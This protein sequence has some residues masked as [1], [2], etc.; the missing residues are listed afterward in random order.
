MTSNKILILISIFLSVCSIE[1]NGAWNLNN[2]TKLLP[3]GMIGSCPYFGNP[4]VFSSDGK[5]VSIG[6]LGDNS[7][8]CNSYAAGSIWNYL[9]NGTSFD[10][11]NP[12]K[13][14]SS[15]PIGQPVFGW[16][17]APSSD[18]NYLAVGG[19]ADNSG[20]G[21]VWV[22][23]KY[24]NGTWDWNDS[25]KLVPTNS[26]GGPGFGDQV[27]FSHN[28]KDL[29]IGGYYD[30]SN[31]G[32]AWVCNNGTTW[33]II[34]KLTPTNPLG[35]ETYFGKSIVFSHNDKNLA[36]RAWYDNI[37]KGAVYFYSKNTDGSWNWT[38]IK[39]TPTSPLG[40]SS[41]FGKIIAFSPDDKFFV[42]G[43]EHDNSQQGAAWVYQRDTN[44]NW[45]FANPIK[46]TPTNAIGSAICFGS[47][48]AFSPDGKHLL[49]GGYAD[50]SEKG[51]VWD[52]VNSETGFDWNNP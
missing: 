51:A 2:S 20:I 6:G 35:T 33:N 22:Y 28:S 37:G 7:G 43:G 14:V 50:N 15:S 10:W 42:V 45:D 13:I 39:L 9:K 17:L 36:I 27:V 44:N 21:A 30:N 19:P 8:D 3:T 48:L 31:I 41:D 11:N 47:A 16:A 18:N 46:L 29:V 12:Q 5:S 1:I 23:S 34:K 52:Y 26:I 32:A 25:V 49:I 4:I 40:T 24:G 38:P